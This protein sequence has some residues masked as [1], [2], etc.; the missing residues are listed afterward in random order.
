[1]R[2]G[3]LSRIPTDKQWDNS[4]DM[5]AALWMAKY[6][7]SASGPTASTFMRMPLPTLHKTLEQCGN[8]LYAPT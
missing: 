6:N 5:K 3:G 8:E 2:H 4:D 7:P 1:M